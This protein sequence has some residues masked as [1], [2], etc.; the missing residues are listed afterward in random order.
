MHTWIIMLTG[1]FKVDSHVASILFVWA[2]HIDL[3]KSFSFKNLFK[4]KLIIIVITDGPSKQIAVNI[5]WSCDSSSDT[6]PSSTD[7]MS[8]YAA[9]FQACKN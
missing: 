1:W 2:A 4:S 3:N 8:S 9:M 5:A 6:T 7:W